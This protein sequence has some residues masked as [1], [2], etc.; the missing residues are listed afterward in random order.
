MYSTAISGRKHR[1]VK[2]IA[3]M[4]EE[5]FVNCSSHAECEAVCPKGISI[6]NIARMSTEDF[7]AL[8]AMSEK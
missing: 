5:G 7:R 1:A 4:D 2:M 8:L 6:V 3:R